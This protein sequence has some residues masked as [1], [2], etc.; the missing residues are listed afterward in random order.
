[1]QSGNDI[2]N[3]SY[4]ELQALALR[5]RVPGNIKKQLL[6]EVL[7]AA[8]C[9]N[10]QEVD[11]LLADM[12]Q[13]R[14]KRIR[15]G[16]PMKLSLSST[17][18][19][20]PVY[21]MADDYYAAQHRL[22]YQWVGAEEEI[23]NRQDE[24]NRVPQ[25][26]EFRQFLLRR[27]Q[28]DY[29]T[30]NTNN[31]DNNNN[32]DM[33]DRLNSGNHG[34]L[35]NARNEIDP[36]ASIAPLNS[37]ETVQAYSEQVHVQNGAFD[38]QILEDPT[39]NGNTSILLRRMLQAPVGA[40]LGEIASPEAQG[41]SC[42]IW[43]GVEY[44]H[45]QTNLLDNSDTLSANSEMNG[46]EEIN[47]WPIG[48]EY[49][50]FVNSVRDQLILNPGNVTTGRTF[51]D[52]PVAAGQ[53]SGTVINTEENAGVQYQLLYANQ[54]NDIQ[55][56][57]PQPWEMVRAAAPFDVEDLTDEKG[58]NYAAKTLP[59]PGGSYYDAACNVV[60]YASSRP[61]EYDPLQQDFPAEE[62]AAT[63]YPGSQNCV[64]DHCGSNAAAPSRPERKFYHD[65]S[66][67][68]EMYSP[69][70]PA[71]SINETAGNYSFVK[72]LGYSGNYNA[73][74][75][76][77]QQTTAGFAPLMQ[78]LS[79]TSTSS[80]NKHIDNFSQLQTTQTEAINRAGNFGCYTYNGPRKVDDQPTI[81]AQQLCIEA[82]GM[83]ITVTKPEAE[84]ESRARR[85]NKTVLMGSASTTLES[86]VTTSL[87]PFWP[88]RPTIGKMTE[89]YLENILNLNTYGYIDYSRIDQ[90]SCIYCYAAPIVTQRLFSGSSPCS[91]KRRFIAEYRQHTFSPYWLLY[92]D[93]RT[94]MQMSKNIKVIDKDKDANESRR[95]DGTIPADS[96]EDAN[97]NEY[98]VSQPQ[99]VQLDMNNIQN[100]ELNGNEL[101]AFRL[102]KEQITAE[103]VVEESP[104]AD[105]PESKWPE[106]NVKSVST[107]SDS[108][109]P[110]NTQLLPNLKNMSPKDLVDRDVISDSTATER[111][112]PNSKARD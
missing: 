60:G 101:Q 97:G 15:K 43:G 20:S 107:R 38:Y 106:Q 42:R 94:G 100:I 78:N 5:Y 1:M 112:I 73:T 92:D 59:A 53:F 46:N 44:N 36:I 54:F 68:S 29:Q 91:Q 33:N 77:Q 22:P 76:I 99:A 71:K 49:Y 93:T 17:P 16:K 27:I 85:Q 70:R 31:D 58:G 45:G 89:N 26:E 63:V 48:S 84:G 3:L 39:G 75:D 61:L 64:V 69:Q 83:P 111:G 90:T 88:Q 32:L 52:Q 74:S 96:E 13:T 41:S 14:K 21:D 81:D 82:G 72:P 10:E 57:C 8:R 34:G 23:P 109:D 86:D 6:I 35:I 2:S 47:N 25:Y 79:F 56:N 66:N 28:R 24:S 7:Q 11:K 9:G 104:S 110:E 55:P 37:L 51:D 40:D 62:G 95:C 80:C 108:N 98:N 4:K 18:I 87:E 50:K 30:Y 103:F 12:R 102:D 65:M 105:P 67:G 19:H